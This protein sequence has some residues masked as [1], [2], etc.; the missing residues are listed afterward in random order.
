MHKTTPQSVDEGSETK[1]GTVDGIATEP[2][3]QKKE[4]FTSGEAT[5]WYGME[6]DAL[7]RWCEREAIT[8]PD[9]QTIAKL[10][11]GVIGFQ[12]RKGARWRFRREK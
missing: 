4:F 5:A 6:E 8:Q 2:L 11:G 7:R 12:V 1:S 10:G 3:V 9:G